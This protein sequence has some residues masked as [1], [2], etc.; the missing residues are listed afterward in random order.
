MKFSFDICEFESETSKK[1]SDHMLAMH[2]K[3]NNCQLEHTCD[4]CEFAANSRKLL[5]SH[6]KEKH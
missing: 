6:L 3:E 5:M 2:G 1:L 4:E